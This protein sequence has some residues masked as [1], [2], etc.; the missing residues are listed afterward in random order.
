MFENI[1]EIKENLHELQNQ[2][3]GL[4]PV[5]LFKTN[6]DTQTIAVTFLS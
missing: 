2:L 1:Y 5:L 3:R 4:C 6:E